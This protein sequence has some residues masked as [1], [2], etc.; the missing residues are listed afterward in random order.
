MALARYPSGYRRQEGEV[1]SRMREVSMAEFVRAHAAGAAVIDVSDVEEYNL[2][3]IPGAASLPLGG[4]S[5]DLTA[6][7][8]QLRRDA[9]VFVV[10]A[11]GNR[12]LIATGMLMHAG[13][14][15][16]SVLGGTNGWVKTGHPVV[17]GDRVRY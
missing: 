16:Y 14:D 12:S 8:C 10:C 13:Y 3:H 5:R 6:A 11:A 17:G 15:A 9:P 2:G 1:L 4:L 7:R